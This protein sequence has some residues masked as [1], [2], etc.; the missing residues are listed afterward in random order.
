MGSST[1]SIPGIT[2][3]D[4]LRELNDVVPKKKRKIVGIAGSLLFIGTL[5]FLGAG[6]KLKGFDITN[7]AHFGKPPI[8]ATQT[9][10]RNDISDPRNIL[11]PHKKPERK[12]KDSIIPKDLNLF[13]IIPD[14]DNCDITFQGNENIERNFQHGCFDYGIKG[15]FSVDDIGFG[16]EPYKKDRIDQFLI[17]NQQFFAIEFGEDTGLYDI[18][19]LADTDVPLIKFPNGTVIF[20]IPLKFGD[21]RIV[22]NGPYPTGFNY[23]LDN[24]FEDDAKSAFDDYH[25]SVLFNRINSEL[26]GYEYLTIEISDVEYDNSPDIPHPKTKRFLVEKAERIVPDLGRSVMLS[27]PILRKMK[28]ENF[29]ILFCAYYSN[30]DEPNTSN[31]D[32]DENGFASYVKGDINHLLGQKGFQFDKTPFCTAIQEGSRL[33]ILIYE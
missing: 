8:E 26:E 1:N 3:D 17:N 23:I 5:A 7:V 22:L 2:S 21:R 14:F 10:R 13:S 32:F 18:L 30:K 4:L 15:W 16:I 25:K 24:V 9:E 6:A 33:P 28:Y 11:I 27:D 20:Y 29:S 12:T 31:L 19:S